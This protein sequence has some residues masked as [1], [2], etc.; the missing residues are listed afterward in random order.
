MAS[1][2]RYTAVVAGMEGVRTRHAAFDLL[3]LRD[4][5]DADGVAF[6]GAPYLMCGAQVRR[7]DLVAGEAITFVAHVE[8]LEGE[9]SAMGGD[10]IAPTRLARPAKL[11]RA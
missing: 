11:G 1:R 6:R 2:T 9:R 3:R 8:G 10:A 7:L 4:I 5:A